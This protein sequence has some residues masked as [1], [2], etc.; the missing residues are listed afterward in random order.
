MAVMDNVLQ[1]AINH[2]RSNPQ[3]ANS[4]MGKAALDIFESGDAA[5]GEQMANNLLDSYGVSRDEAL[6]RAAS[7]FGK[8]NNG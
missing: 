8:G 5:R 7:F 2:I 4:P 6:Q 3:V 1:A